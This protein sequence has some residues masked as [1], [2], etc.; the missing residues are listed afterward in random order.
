MYKNSLP[1][2]PLP[3]SIAQ[4]SGVALREF[5]A[6]VRYLLDINKFSNEKNYKRFGY[7][8]N[9][10]VIAIIKLVIEFVC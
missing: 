8:S 9:L 7:H 5:G 10:A 6:K 2:L 1:T 3:S 4:E